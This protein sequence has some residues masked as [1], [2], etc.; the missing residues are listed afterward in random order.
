MHD[1]YENKSG[2]DQIAQESVQVWHMD[3]IEY[4][5]GIKLYLKGCDYPQKG[6]PTPE[7]L[8]A[9][10]AVKK[11]LLV[12]MRTFKGSLIFVRVKKLVKAFNEI[13]WRIISP[14]VL[15]EEYQQEFT[16]EIDNLIYFFLFAYGIEADDA[17]RCASIMSHIF[18][19]DW[20]YRLR[21]QDLFGE[22]N[23]EMLQ[24]NPR[25]ELR[26]LLELNRVR[27]FKEANDKFKMFARMMSWV[28]FIPRVRH[29]FVTAVSLVDFSKLVPDEGDRY[30]MLQRLDY[31]SFGKTLEERKEM[32][33]EYNVVAGINV[34]R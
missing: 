6:M 13:G 5:G 33:K 7:A 23:K 18:E 24:D 30:W 28:F 20:A 11:I 34:I 17:N 3:R 15:K 21:L 19:Y 12:G 32:L 4:D 26:R 27:D 16:R 22:T 14:Y 1:I 31:Q 25:S 8:F 2:G 10:N 9:V 29:S